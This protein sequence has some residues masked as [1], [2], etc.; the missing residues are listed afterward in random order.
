M[1]NSINQVD[2][3]TDMVKSIPEFM[4]AVSDV[5]QS[6]YGWLVLVAVLIWFLINRDLSRLFSL[7][8]RGEKQRLDKLESYVNNPS[9]ADEQSL[10]V[11][12]DLRNAYYFKVATGIYAEKGRRESLIKL[13]NDTSHSINWVQIKRALPFIIAN[14]DMNPSIRDMEFREKVVHYYN[15][16]VGFLFLVFAIALLLMFLISKPQNVS[17]ILIG[18]GGAL[19]PA[20]FAMFVFS[21]N[22]P[23]ASAK[24]IKKELE[25]ISAKN[26]SESG[27]S[28]TGASK[29]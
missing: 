5:L 21:Q 29:D 26:E 8:E 15:L 13:H 28:V 16:A 11:I 7:F 17:G 6:P 2:K 22:L 18:L 1:P 19:T 25:H 14:A 24:K 9:A 4:T 23:F 27:S 20:L 12:K 3:A 10:N